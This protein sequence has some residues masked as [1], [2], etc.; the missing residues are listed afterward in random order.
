MIVTVDHGPVRELRLARP[1]VNALNPELL[2]ALRVAIAQAREDSCGAIVL[3][4]SPGRFSG[5]LDVPQLLQLDRSEMRATW[6]LFFAL[7]KDIA[8]SDLPIAAALTGHSPAG[9]TVLAIFADFRVLAEGPYL[10]GLNEVRVGLPVPEVLYRALVHVVGARQAERLAVGGLLLD[11]AEALRAGL[12]DEV[13]PVDDVIPRAVAW[14]TDLLSR[15]AVAM[16]TTRR[17]ARRPLQE[18]FDI[19]TPTMLDGLADQWFSAE[20]QSVMRA[21]ASKLGQRP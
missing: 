4:G 7:L 2:R 19:V 18:A 13:V 12:V 8:C 14:T 10:V 3:S 20:T 21:L 17:R 9:G 5:G 15:P 6:E 11:P 16:S 1:P